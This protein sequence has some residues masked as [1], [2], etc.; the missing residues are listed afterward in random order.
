MKPNMKARLSLLHKTE[1]EWDALPTF[2][3]FSGEVIIF[4]PDKDHNYARM[5]IGDGKTLLKELPFFIDSAVASYND[6][7]RLNEIIDGGRISSFKK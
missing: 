4:S 1:A 6:A 3:P 2:T 7:H 5:K